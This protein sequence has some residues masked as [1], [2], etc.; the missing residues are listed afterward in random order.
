MRGKT[1]EVAINCRAPYRC[2]LLYLLL[3]A[4]AAAAATVAAVFDSKASEQ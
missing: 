1:C 3:A 2:Y 4:A